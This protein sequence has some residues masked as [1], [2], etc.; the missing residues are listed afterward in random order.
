M[1]KNLKI[2]K[3][4]DI[5]KSRKLSKLFV[6]KRFLNLKVR[7]KLLICFI[8]ISLYI[9]MVGI[10]SYI[11]M[12]AINKGNEHIYNQNLVS[13][14]T[15][16]QIQKNVISI[17]GE[18][19]VVLLKKNAT[20]SQVKIEKINNLLEENNKLLLQYNN[21]NIISKQDENNTL[22]N[23][24][25]INCTKQILDLL[26]LISENKFEE[27]DD[28]FERFNAM[29]SN[30]DNNLQNLIIIHKESAKITNITNKN[31]FVK[32]SFIILAI[33]VSG[34]IIAILLGILISGVISKGLNKSV[35]FAE[36][37]SE[38]NLT[39]TIDIDSNDEI[40]VLSK[41][42]NKASQNTK[43]LVVSII[44][45]VNKVNTH[46][47]EMHSSTEEI[48]ADIQSVNESTYKINSDINHINVAVNN[49][50]EL[51]KEMI[52]SILLVSDKAVNTSVISKEI[53][54]RAT[55]VK[56]KT[57][58][59]KKIVSSI[60]VENKA[61]ILKAIENGK[62]VKE[63]KVMSDLI[64]NIA[65]QTKLLSLNASIEAARAGQQG[66]G[67][68]VVADEIGKLAKLSTDTVSDIK[69]MVNLVE[70]AFDYIGQSSNE[71]L[72]LIDTK[73]SKDYDLM[74]DMGNHY[75][76]DSEY[77]NE[78]SGYLVYSTTDMKNIIGKTN[79]SIQSVLKLLLEVAGS[80]NQIAASVC[81]TSKAM[82]YIV[83]GRQDQSNQGEN[84]RQLV[85]QFK[86]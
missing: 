79:T 62:I 20:V 50:S 36:E 81:E 16:A 11:S 28:L 4:F 38:G 57:L 86:I 1:K 49:I 9:S 74:L 59:S 39:K 7:S 77:M 26:N 78:F 2:N 52:S 10:S 61:N 76:E 8:A 66:R 19:E 30:L 51:S 84:L 31:L 5:K 37:L 3:L 22:L 56:N 12:K 6:M 47:S 24:T 69:N 32:S 72:E 34:F 43:K 65:K 44:E 14:Q 70:E 68:A 64:D 27:T 29:S 18:L 55:N 35:G 15:L 58:E 21:V 41:A 82:D 63:I 54:E 53:K 83:S 46:S 60:Y 13:I 67:F 48:S 85:Q 45:Q 40:G 71:I 75:Q 23:S 80:S 17:K 42:L 33:T 73:I 25:N